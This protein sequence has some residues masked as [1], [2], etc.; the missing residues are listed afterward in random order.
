MKY[1]RMVI[2]HDSTN[3]NSDLYSLT[4]CLTNIAFFEFKKKSWGVHLLGGNLWNP[5]VSHLGVTKPTL[6]RMQLDVF[7]KNDVAM[8]TSWGSFLGI[9]RNK[10]SNNGG[11]MGDLAIIMY[12]GDMG[13]YQIIEGIWRH[14]HI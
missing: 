9:W 12:N 8:E 6:V 14:H 2:Q 13:G 11:T 1:N 5:V 3:R 4:I 10:T 7:I